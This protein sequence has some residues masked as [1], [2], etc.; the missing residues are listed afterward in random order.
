[1][2]LAEVVETGVFAAE[3]VERLQHHRSAVARLARRGVL[4]LIAEL[5]VQQLLVAG[6]R[7]RQQFGVI[8]EAQVVVH[9]RHELW[10]RIGDLRGRL[11]GKVLQQFFRRRALN[12]RRQRHEHV[13]LR[14]AALF[15]QAFHD[16]AGA[17]FDVLHLD[18]GRLGEGVELRL[19]PAVIAVVQTIGGVDGHHRLGGPERRGAEC[20]GGHHD[21][22]RK[23]HSFSLTVTG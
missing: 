3:A 1:M 2:Q 6:G 12:E 8:D 20:D 14:V 9:Q 19:I 4:Q 13:G 23:F 11:R 21:Q 16:G 15:R 10:L 18:A 17:T 7:L 22:S 5:R